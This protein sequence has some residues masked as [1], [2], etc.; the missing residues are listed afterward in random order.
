MAQHIPIQNIKSMQNVYNG[1]CR[2]F[3]KGVSSVSLSL[4]Y[5]E[6]DDENFKENK[7]DRVFNTWRSISGVRESFEIHFDEVNN[8]ITNIYLIK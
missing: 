2:Q 8:K 4:K 6:I 1:I 7:N 3:E 5:Q